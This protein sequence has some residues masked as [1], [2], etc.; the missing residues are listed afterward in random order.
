MLLAWPLVLPTARAAD[1]SQDI[2]LVR[3]TFTETGTLGVE[4]ADLGP[5]GSVRFNVGLQLEHAPVVALRRTGEVVDVIA[6]RVYGASFG[7]W[8]FTRRVAVTLELPPLA[9][10]GGGTGIYAAN[11]A[12][13]G[14]ATVGVRVAAIDTPRTGLV[15]RTDLVLPTGT[16][17]TWTSEPIPRLRVGWALEQRWPGLTVLA[18][19]GVTLRPD[20]VD[21]WDYA[22]RSTADV[23][24][25]ARYQPLSFLTLVG[26]FIG[27]TV[28]L[29]QPFGAAETP[30][31]VLAG[32]ELDTARHF[33]VGVGVGVG[34]APGVGASRV[35]GTLTLGWYARIR[36][37]EPVPEPV[38]EPCVQI[39]DHAPVQAW[40]EGDLAMVSG[41]R[42]LL[43]DPI[44]F[45]PGTAQVLPSSAS[46]VQELATLLLAE[47][48]IRVL[49]IEGHAQT[50]GGFAASFALSEARAR[51]IFVALVEA[52]VAP[53]R[54]SY[55]GMGEVLPD[56]DD[57][58]LVL[59]VADWGRLEGEIPP[60]VVPWTG[61]AKPPPPPDPDPFDLEDR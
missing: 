7:S 27:R 10:Q 15:G 17:D 43:R 2:E 38:E 29:D 50:D 24:V 49:L 22:S 42:V 45:A 14:D 26:A 44:R 41:D 57:R 52:G 39:P 5:P 32:A 20:T 30:A 11:G 31:E 8:T 9:L 33:F 55:R 40:E 1:T 61:V 28:L 53:G 54:L 23:G 12:A 37:R 16:T 36:P 56:E 3:P 48:R 4:G 6:T 46:M 60:T 18:D 58:E 19:L 34:V 51:T 47:P 35:R 21:V 13:A 25:A 59:R